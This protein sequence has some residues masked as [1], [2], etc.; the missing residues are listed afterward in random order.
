VDMIQIPGELSGLIEH[1]NFPK[2]FFNHHAGETSCMYLASCSED[3]LLYM[4]ESFYEISGYAPEKIFEEGIHWWFSLIHPEDINRTLHSIFQH[5]FFKPAD[6][7]LNKI[8]SLLYRIKHANKNW[9]WVSEMKC[10]ISLTDEGKNNLILGTLEDVSESKK[11]E[12]D[13]VREL[14]RAEGKTNP[15]I[16]AAIQLIDA[17]QTGFSFNLKDDLQQKGITKREKEILY[18]IGEGYSTKQIADKL[19]ISI[20]TVETHRRNL[21]EKMQVKNSMQLVKLTANSF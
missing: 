10:V 9:V 20:Y 2:Y 16:R 19:F 1:L 4:H 3:Q 13:Q 7:R 14:F 8:F 17:G 15:V 11:K 18:L 21:L 6:K 5:C 12:D